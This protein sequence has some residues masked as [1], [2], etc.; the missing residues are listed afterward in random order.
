[1]TD[2]PG[3]P[4]GRRG[5][6]LLSESEVDSRR[7]LV[8]LLEER[9]QALLAQLR[10]ITGNSAT[11]SLLAAI[12]SHRVYELQLLLQAHADDLDAVNRR[13]D[14]TQLTPLHEAAALGHSDVAAVLITNGADVFR[15]DG[16]GRLP[17]QLAHENR[18]YELRNYLIIRQQEA[19]MAANKKLASAPRSDVDEHITPQLQPI[20][21]LS[22]PSPT[23]GTKSAPLESVSHESGNFSGRSV[24]SDGTAAAQAAGLTPGSM[25]KGAGASTAMPDCP[26]PSPQPVG[27]RSAGVSSSSVQTSNPAHN[28]LGSSD[29]GWFGSSLPASTQHQGAAVQGEQP[30]QHTQLPVYQPLLE[31]SMSQGGPDGAGGEPPSV[32]LA[33]SILYEPEPTQTSDFTVVSDT[34]P[35]IACMVGLP[36]RGKSYISKHIAKYLNWKGVPCRVFNA[37]NYRRKLLGAEATA[38]ADFF[39]PSNPQAKEQREEMA[40]MAAADAAAFV[41]ASGDD[42]KLG[43]QRSSRRVAILDATN[44]TRERREKLIAY[45][46]TAAPQARILFIESVCSDPAVIQENILRAKCGGEDFRHVADPKAVVEEFNQRIRNYEKVYQ[47]LDGDIETNVTFIKI[48][49][50]K[51]SVILHRVSG[52]IA[53]RL[54]YFLMN[55]ACVQQPLYLCISA[56]SEGDLQSEFSDSDRLT[57]EGS[58][59]S[60]ALCNFIESR[61][62]SGSRPDVAAEP[63]FS[64]AFSPLSPSAVATIDVVRRSRKSSH[65]SWV[66]STALK[67]IALGQWK[68]LTHGAAQSQYN[69]E[70]RRL[71][72]DRRAMQQRRAGDASPTAAGA[73]GLD[74]TLPKADQL[75]PHLT[76]IFT[77]SRS[78]FHIRRYTAAYPSGES[79]RQVNLRLEPMIFEALQARRPMLIV[80]KPTP[81]QGILAYFTG[82]R[83]EHSPHICIP[84]HRII[85]I[86]TAKGTILIHDPTIRSNSGLSSSAPSSAPS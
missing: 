62:N 48:L 63:D 61:L 50:V 64:V 37:G 73:A 28:M 45:F 82:V 30:P 86:D 18:H 74:L 69:K 26:Y 77:S 55:L 40:R 33:N 7:Q 10:F 4:R 34:V 2:Q 75:Y 54:T 41:N 5:S 11:A 19:A 79:C 56:E 46:A 49:D 70:Y 43:E 35:W 51:D 80:A 81:A 27:P 59:F 47:A 9:K 13:D 58:A 15:L 57:A 38:G 14:A 21:H 71:F 68:G 39:D 52:T 65:V 22:R 24:S 3:S 1:M 8:Q 66:E 84:R 25:S 83:P 31:N 20:T 32:T 60:H 6:E 23:R 12:R 36:G 78:D 72:I 29:A 76:Q 17:S 53:T 85:E 67:D 42:L 44:T 16:A